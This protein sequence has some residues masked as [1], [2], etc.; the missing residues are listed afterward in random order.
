MRK[1][2]NF[3]DLQRPPTPPLLALSPWY[4]LLLLNSNRMK[5]LSLGKGVETAQASR[6]KHHSK[7]QHI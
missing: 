6:E 7:T 5:L 2:F 4:C 1:C 3:G